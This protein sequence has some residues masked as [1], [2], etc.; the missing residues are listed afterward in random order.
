[1]VHTRYVLEGTNGT[2]YRSANVRSAP[3]EEAHVFMQKY[4][5]VRQQEKLKATYPN[6]DYEIKP[7]IIAI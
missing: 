4:Q 1:M 7:V 6:E 5:A 3:F 2:F